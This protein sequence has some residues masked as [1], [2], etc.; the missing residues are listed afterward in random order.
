MEIV[1]IVTP[2]KNRLPLLRGALES[3]RNQSYA[4]WEHIV[5]DDGS[6]DGT[7]EELLR[8]SEQDER[9]RYIQRT[10]LVKGANVCRNI[11]LRESRGKYVIF[12]DS[13]DLLSRECIKARVELIERN[14]DLD[15]LTFEPLGFHSV[16][17][18][19]GQNVEWDQNGD[20]LLRFLYFD[21][22][23]TIT[24]PIW[25]RS[26]LLELGGFDE[27][28]PSWQDFELH[29]RA[30]CRGAKYIRMPEVD[31]FVRVAPDAGRI[32]QDLRRSTGHLSEALTTIAKVEDHVRSGPGLTWPRRRAICS[33]YY[34]VA[35]W[36]VD[37][38]SLSNS[39]KTWRKVI[40]HRIGDNLLFMFGFTLLVAKALGLPVQRVRN[41]WMGLA[42][43]R[44][45]P[46]VG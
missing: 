30:L 38:G 10:G 22:P 8:L 36:W 40:D 4:C 16:P 44:A 42:R 6:D 12:L 7:A 45:S 5:V 33:L 25:R 17:G 11:G 18:D 43:L 1:S 26:S 29:V 20:H 23:W 15:F 31:H 14:A 41:R 24:G 3:V 19:K 34:Y 27:S 37:S 35:E 46:Q 21:V 9:I 32:T 2:T 39:L 28:L 13:D